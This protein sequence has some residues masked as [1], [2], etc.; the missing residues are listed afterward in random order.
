M[1]QSMGL[2]SDRTATSLSFLSHSFS[3][4]M[5]APKVKM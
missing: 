2:K 3:D 1:L 5:R 4:E